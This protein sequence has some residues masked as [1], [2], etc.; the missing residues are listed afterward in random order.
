METKVNIHLL[1]TDKESNI[2][3]NSKNELEY[4]KI[5]RKRLITESQQIYLTLPQSDLEISKIGIGDWCIDPTF[6][7]GIICIYQVIDNSKNKI[8]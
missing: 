1:P 2:H 8:W 3:L 7:V 4:I 5:S 6:Y